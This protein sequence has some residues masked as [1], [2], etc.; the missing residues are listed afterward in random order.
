MVLCGSGH[1][2]LGLLRAACH[3]VTAHCSPRLR[4]SQHFYTTPCGS[5][6]LDSRRD[7][8]WPIRL[9]SGQEPATLKALHWRLCSA[10]VLSFSHLP[11]QIIYDHSSCSGVFPRWRDICQPSYCCCTQLD[12]HSRCRMI[13]LVSFSICSLSSALVHVG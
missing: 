10:I 3:I 4:K 6:H 1:P 8:L 11:S 7:E 9:F 5:S 13:T 2:V 12:S